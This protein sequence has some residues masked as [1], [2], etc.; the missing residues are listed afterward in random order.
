MQVRGCFGSVF[1]SYDSSHGLCLQKPRK[2][3]GVRLKVTALY[4][5]YC[6][7]QIMLRFIR[8]KFIEGG[9]LG[10]AN[11]PIRYDL[12]TKS[13]LPFSTWIRNPG[14]NILITCKVQNLGP[15]NRSIRSNGGIRK[16]IKISLW[17]RNPGKTIFKI[18]RSVHP[19]TPLI[20]LILA[21][22]SPT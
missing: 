10:Y 22:I 15:K 17:I 16:S 5:S 8:V 18:C 4:I 2:I 7:R 1:F 9:E 6:T 14:K 3:P 12:L 19:F 20:I 11:L 21:L 13:A